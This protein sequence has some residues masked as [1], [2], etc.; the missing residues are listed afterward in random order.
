MFEGAITALVTPLRGDRVDEEALRRHVEAQI[1]AGID[2]LVPCGT[3]GESPTLSAEEQARVIRIVVDQAR[4]RVPVIAG[5][6]SNATAHAA[7]LARAAREAG[8]DGLLVV[9]PYYNKPT[10]E[11]LIAHFR[12]VVD[13]GR[14]PT[15][16]YNVPGRTGCD[17]L[18]DTIARLTAVPE[19]VAVKEATGSVT[20]AQDII[21]RC[22][23]RIAVLSGD[24]FTCF[25]LYTVGARGVITVTSNVVPAL[26][27]EQWDAAHAGDW[28]RARRLHYRLLP[29]HTA[30]FVEANPIPVKAA[31]HL[32][33]AMSPEIR[34]PLTPLGGANLEKLRAALVAEGLLA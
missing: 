27:A 16:L 19:V 4:R 17:L 23:D 18:P 3:T 2:G 14:L 26:M 15:I 21:A 20:R 10:Q 33:G 31:M 28:E 1:A 7:A 25:P 13:A 9:T 5:A 32:I 12:A 34:L 24:D 8:A 30:M 22:G 29:L 11:G 6:G